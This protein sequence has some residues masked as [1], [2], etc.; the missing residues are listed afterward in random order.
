MMDSHVKISLHIAINKENRVFI[1]ESR[2]ECLAS[3][4]KQCHYRHCF[5]ENFEQAAL[6]YTLIFL[7]FT[8]T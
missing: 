2:V 4:W 5:G 7:W 1:I 8:I 6:V 3:A